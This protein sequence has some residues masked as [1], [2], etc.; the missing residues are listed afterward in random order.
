MSTVGQLL[1]RIT[2]L[3]TEDQLILYNQLTEYLKNANL[4]NN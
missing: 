3:S 4:L 2:A 1:T